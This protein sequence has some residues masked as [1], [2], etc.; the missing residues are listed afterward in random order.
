MIS[1]RHLGDSLVLSVISLFRHRS[2]SDNRHLDGL[3]RARR[4]FNGLG[5]QQAT[6]G[7]KR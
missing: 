5:R 7:I 4:N 2:L 6:V 1:M 3:E